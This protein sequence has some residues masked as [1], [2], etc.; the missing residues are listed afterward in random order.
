MW[1]MYDPRLFVLVISPLYL[2]LRLFHVPFPLTCERSRLNWNLCGTT[3]KWEAEL[4][5]LGRLDPAKDRN[6]EYV[7]GNASRCCALI[8]RLALPG[9]GVPW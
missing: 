5:R 7:Y 3:K 2:R 9:H 1:N 6:A 8:R 4:H